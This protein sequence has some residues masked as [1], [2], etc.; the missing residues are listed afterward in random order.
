LIAICIAIA[1]AVGAA[2]ACH[3]DTCHDDSSHG[4]DEGSPAQVCAC[5]CH[6]PGAANEKSAATPIDSGASRLVLCVRLQPG[7][8]ILPDIYRPPALA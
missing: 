8:Q 7:L 6:Q 4:N 1:V 3:A 5:M 2:L